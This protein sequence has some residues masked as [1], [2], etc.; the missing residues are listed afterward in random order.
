MTFLK[1]HK[2]YPEVPLIEIATLKRGYD[3]PTQNRAD[4]NIPIFAANGQNGSHSEAKAFGPGVVTGRS[5]T[6]GKVHYVETDYW[7]L[8]TSLYVTNFHGNHPKW[9]FYM[10]QAFKLDRFVE[11]AGVPTL[12]RN[13]VHGEK[14]PLPPLAEQKRIAAILDKADSLRRKNQ[15]AIQLADQFLRAM[16]LDMF[17]DPVTN[18]KG[19][20]EMTLSDVVKDGTIIT[21][22]IV[23]AGAEVE[24]GVPYIRTGDFKN[25]CL[26]KSGYARTHSDIAAKFERSKVSTGDLVYC[27]RASIG[28]VDIV[29]KFLDGA[30]LTQGTAKISPGNNIKAEFLVEFLRTKGFRDWIDRYSKGATFKEITLERLRVAPVLVPPLH[31]QEKFIAI[32][33]KTLHAIQTKTNMTEIPLFE[34][35][36]QKAFAG[37]L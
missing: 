35:L 34:S 3:L 18:P 17:G 31:I 5:G 1:N 9:V 23:Q 13:L 10:L 21:Y 2:G 8:N 7:P 4:G 12:N 24:N 30:N 32:R 6:I 27:I 22:G 29:P 28:S 26:V 11:G 14:I 25:G 16:F 15:Q 37:E 19:W 36:S 20:K 33:N